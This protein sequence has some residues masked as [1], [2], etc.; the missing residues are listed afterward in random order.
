M[1]LCSDGLTGELSDAQIQQIC[2]S[3]GT[4]EAMVSELV[5]AANR[6]GGK[7][8]ISCIVLGLSGPAAPPAEERPRGF[9]EKLLKPAKS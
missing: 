4:L 2:T 5:E 1:L 6:E 3:A 9:F 7:D 8:N